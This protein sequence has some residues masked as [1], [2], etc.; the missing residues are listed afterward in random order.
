ML[1]QVAET[2]EAVD[3]SMASYRF[4]E[5]IDRLYEVTRHS[6]CDWYVE[7]I[8]PRLRDDADER[9]RAAAAQT[10]ITTL[11]VLLRLLHPFMPFI[12]EECAQRLPGAAASLQLRDWPQ[13][14]DDWREG[15]AASHRAAVEE[16]LQLVSRLRT[17]RDENGVPARERHRLQIRGGDP[18]MSAAERRRLVTTLVPVDVDEAERELEGGV[19]LVAGKLEARYHLVM[20][21]RERAHS[22]RRLLEVAKTVDRLERQLGNEGFT[23]GARP[24]VVEDARRRLEEARRE[25]VALQAQ[26]ESV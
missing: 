11:D 21:E 5:A 19:S 9:S 26:L 2:V 22:Q 7:M 6:F 12:T 25:R 14:A 15:L 17:L 23:T 3:A 8:K 16:L 20:G 10:A 18:D 24:E 4:H 13:V 1:S